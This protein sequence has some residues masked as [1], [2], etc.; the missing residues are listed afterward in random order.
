MS[1][2][3]SSTLDRMSLAGKVAVV[4]GGAGAIGQVYA[5]ALAEAGAQVVL[6][7]LDAE[8]A[9]RA[10]KSLSADGLS[11]LGV[12]VD[13]TDRASAAAMAQQAISTF[14][15]ID[16]L[17]N[18]AALMADIPQVDLLELPAEW[19]DRVMRVNVYGAIVC[20][21]A[22]K[23]SMVE[24]GGGRIINQVSAG[25]FMGGGIYG[26]SK[27]A[28]VNVTVGLARSLGPLGINVNAVAPGLVEN[29][30]GFKSL[31]AEHPA[32][33]ALASAIPG[34]KSA[35]AEDLLGTLLLLA[36]PAG[37]WINGQTISVDGGWVTRL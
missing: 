22:V 7:D 33:A 29:E 25:A 12:R 32:R 36:S 14:G 6:A 11:A 3:T 8:G 24:R 9:E 1:S 35:P 17:V 30:P 19:F 10:A 21:G 16:I 5:R 27:L 26:V 18:N 28:L 20:A 23:A 37:E 13:I 2:T 4:T 15:G 34:K 31:P